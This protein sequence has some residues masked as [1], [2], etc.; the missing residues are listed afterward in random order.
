M[1]IVP[2][3]PHT[4]I[5]IDVFNISVTTNSYVLPNIHL[6]RQPN[7]RFNPSEIINTTTF[8]AETFIKITAD[9][10]F[11]VIKTN[12]IYQSVNTNTSLALN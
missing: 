8:M 10:D 7:N 1:G 5:Q 11:L 9:N 3:I 4:R 2:N 12:I 6:I